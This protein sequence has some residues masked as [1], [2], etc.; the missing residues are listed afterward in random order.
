MLLLQGRLSSLHVL[1]L[2]VR[3]KTLVGK[4]GT[5]TA[6]L[7]QALVATRDITICLIAKL[8]NLE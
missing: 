7:R 6:L 5:A 4:P 8:K 3:L 2:S 1:A